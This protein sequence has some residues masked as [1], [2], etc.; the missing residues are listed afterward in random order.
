MHLAMCKTCTYCFRQLK[1][2]QKVFNSYTY[3][4]S[5]TLTPSNLSL[6]KEAIARIKSALREN[7]N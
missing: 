5:A 7:S 1:A 4:I 6:S 3:A 2:L